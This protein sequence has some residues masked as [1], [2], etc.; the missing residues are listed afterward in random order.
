MSIA[1]FFMLESG[2]PNPYYAC[3]KCGASVP[4]VE[5]CLVE[6][7]ELHNPSPSD[8]PQNIRRRSMSAAK[9]RYAAE[10]ATEMEANLEETRRITRGRRASAATARAEQ[11]VAMLRAEQLVAMVLDDIKTCHGELGAD[12]APTDLSTETLEALLAHQKAHEFK[13]PGWDHVMGAFIEGAREARLNPT[14]TDDDFKRAA[15]GYTKRVHEEVDPETERRLRENDWP[16][17]ADCK[18]HAL[19]CSKSWCV[20]R[21]WHSGKHE[22]LLRADG[23]K[24]RFRTQAG[25]DAAIV[26]ADA[27]EHATLAKANE[28]HRRGG[29]VVHRQLT[30]EEA[31]GA[32]IDALAA[33]P[34][35]STPDKLFG[36][37][38]YPANPIKDQ[39]IK[40]RDAADKFGAAIH[41]PIEANPPANRATD[42]AMERDAVRYRWLRNRPRGLL[43]GSE[44]TEGACIDEWHAAGGGFQLT[45]EEADAAIDAA[46]AQ[47]QPE[48]AATPKDATK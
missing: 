7:L 28:L 48:P 8:T 38:A 15:D 23:Q 5:S 33:M 25:A 37:N 6:H 20:R 13:Q 40:I 31:H 43:A 27:E 19:P 12:W 1:E 41:Q 29:E 32:I 24:R 39:I 45:G 30:P 21:I 2:G 3:K 10:R 47:A 44:F 9:E 34:N 46:L 22:Y 26:V 16:E 36:L 17:V 4:G 14:A 42:E 35:V 11:L 18:W